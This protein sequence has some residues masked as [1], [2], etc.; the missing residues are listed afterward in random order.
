MKK[1]IK[2]VSFGLAIAGVL[3]LYIGCSMMTEAKRVN[4]ANMAEKTAEEKIVESYYDTADVYEIFKIYREYELTP[5]ILTNRKGSLV[6]EMVIGKCI[7]AESGAG[8]VIGKEDEHY[9]YISYK[10]VPGVKTNDIV[11]SYLL[12][13][14]DNNYEDDIIE[15]YDFI[16]DTNI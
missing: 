1:Y 4:A 3:S 10:N 6:I 9:N 8:V 14:P 11:C 7:D 2:L 13:N 5:E 15:R 16:L 12:Y